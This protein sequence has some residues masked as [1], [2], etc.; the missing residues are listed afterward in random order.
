[1]KLPNNDHDIEQHSRENYPSGGNGMIPT[2]LRSEKGL[3][4]KEQKEWIEGMSSEQYQRHLANELEYQKS[5]GN[6]RY[7]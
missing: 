7:Y 1:M 6:A 4:A 3:A 5:K 2:W